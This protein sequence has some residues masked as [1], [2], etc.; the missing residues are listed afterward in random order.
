MT[1]RRRALARAAATTALL[2]M[3]LTA[4][5]AHA[6]P[7]TGL[8]AARTGSCKTFSDARPGASFYQAITW[9][10]CEGIT[11]GYADGTYGTTRQISRAET[12]AF[13]YRLAKPKFTAPRTSPFKDM[14]AGS[15]WAYAP[16][17]W[18]ASEGISS[19]YADGTFK[20]QRHISRGEFAKIV[21]GVLDPKPSTKPA[22]SFPDVKAGAGFHRSIT[23]LASEG[24]ISGY[25][26]GTF[27]PTRNITRGE[28]A[29]ILYGIAPRIRQDPGTSPDPAPAP[30]TVPASFTVTGS[31]WG[32]GVGMSQFGARAMAAG[33]STAGQILSHYYNPATV[34]DSS[35]RAAEDI[36]VH[37]ASA[38]TSTITARTITGTTG[39]LRVDAGDAPLTS[40]TGAVSLAVSGGKVIATLPN[41]VKKTGTRINLEWPGT[42]PWSGTPTT[43]RVPNANGTAG[44]LELRHGHLTVTVTGGRL[45]IVNELRMT[46]EYLYGLAEMPSSWPAAALQSQAIAS[47]SYAL[48]NMGSVKTACDCHVWDEVQSQKFTGWGKENERS[49][50]THW[51]GRWTGAVDATLTRNAAGTPTRAKSLWYG[52]AVA[53][54]TY[55]SANGGHTRNSQDVW[56]SAVP[57]LT[58]RPDPYSMAAAANNPNA[59]WTATITQAQLAKA[60]G[61]KDIVGVSIKQGADLTPA[62]LTAITAT[63]K[64][65]TITGRAFRTAIPLKAAWLRS[66]TAR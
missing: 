7:T 26:D 40:S 2:A 65:V 19:G 25:S 64:T 39:R 1:T 60:F 12:A 62:S 21:H 31:G 18:L 22:K 59:T 51:G 42:R 3:T 16:V 57:Y 6:A 28:V 32:H 33:G 20:P 45:N 8:P 54:A 34:A 66:I 10:S 49:A 36:K 17:S 58:A 14:A 63:G 24:I 56:A 30:V 27:R 38:A 13:L 35:H 44:T 23:W 37:L 47:R 50:T 46:D 15:G 5:P 9:M 61:V 4:L 55:Y 43:V 48:R 52:G 41:G 29:K 53:D 11:G